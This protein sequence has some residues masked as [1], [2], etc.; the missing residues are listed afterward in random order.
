METNEI[1]RQQ[2][3]NVIKNQMKD[4]NPPETKI[5]YD[6]L[7][8]QGF[9]DFVTRQMIGQC[10]AVEL[11]EVLKFGKPFDNERYIKNLSGLPKEPFD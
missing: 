7:R 2:I 5:A 4:N 9:D 6:R 10:V 11:F 3:F 8:K 1:L